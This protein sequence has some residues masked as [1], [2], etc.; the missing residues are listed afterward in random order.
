MNTDQAWQDH[1]ALLYRSEAFAEDIEDLL[2]SP[3]VPGPARPAPL[4]ASWLV[5]LPLAVALLGSGSA[6]A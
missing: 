6:L 2:Q 3:L 5:V 1:S 4:R